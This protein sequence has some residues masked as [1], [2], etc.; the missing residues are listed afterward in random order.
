MQGLM[1]DQP[2]LISSLLEHAVRV[3]PRAEIVS[4]LC[5]GTLHRS[6]YGAV[7][8]RAKRLANAL[9]A[10][11]VE[12][13]ARVGTLA[14]NTHRHM[15]LYF[16]VSGKGAVLN[17][18]NPRLF[19]EQIEYIV[20]HAQDQVLFFD[21][22]FAPLVA[23]LAPR[24]ACVRALVCMTDRA[25]MPQGLPPGTLCYEELLE[26]ASE[27]YDWPQF[28]ER[29]A[30]ALCYTSGTT[31][32]PKGVLYSHRST[33]LHAMG[34]CLAGTAAISQRDSCLVVVPLFH[35]NAWGMPY[36]GALSG[37]KLVLPGPALDGASIYALLR[38]ERVTMALGVPTVW[39]GLLNHVEGEARP[40][41][42]ELCLERLLC[43]GSAIPPVMFTRCSK[44]LG[45]TLMQAWG[46]TEMSPLG[47]VCSLLQSHDNASDEEKLRVQARQGRPVC[48]VELA[49]KDEDGKRLPHDG[50]TAGRLMVRGPW[51]LSA[52]YGSDA[53]VLDEEGFFDTGDIANIDADGYLQITDRAKDVIKSG[54][55]WI[56]SI[57]VENAVLGHPAIA[58]AAVIGVAHEK[59]QER[60]LLVVVA[61]EGC[62]PTRD[63]VLGY[64]ASRVA[65]WWLPDD[66]VFVS[67]LPYSANGKVQKMKLRELFKQYKKAE[68]K[69][70]HKPK[71]TQG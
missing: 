18:I 45:A 6:S 9:Q 34:L 55:E 50:V 44:T 66:V 33:Y 7:A 27:H 51:I 13:G 67:E 47:T 61:R 2:L 56:S 19:P 57:D 54:G 62:S 16:A 49:L 40:A 26:G 59:W 70:V 1:Q 24:L 23:A 63:E 25:H 39:L 69:A 17:T 42:Q 48:G 37:A 46:M 65:K 29:S 71:E 5:E 22:S 58:A 21:L 43:G 35:V 10:L 32:N 31:G 4:R 52:Y 53:P 28:D 60:P 3:H 36:A 41:R 64:L 12:M 38:D 15:E 30:S 11:G 14:W 20:Q 68:Y 8:R